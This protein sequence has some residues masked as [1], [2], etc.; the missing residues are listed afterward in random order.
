MGYLKDTCV[1][2]DSINCGEEII[3]VARHCQNNGKNFCVTDIVIDELTPGRKVPEAQAEVSKGIKNGIQVAILGKII[4]KF[5]VLSDKSKYKSNFN[6]IRKKYYGHLKDR[7]FIQE[8]IKLGNIT[9]EQAKSKGF[10]YKGYGECSCIAVA[11]DNPQKYIIV[12]NDKGAITLKPKINLF[13]KYNETHGIIVWDYNEWVKNTN[14][15]NDK[16]VKT[17]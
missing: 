6:K 12:T 7:G 17:S 13:K 1:L 16:N 15:K 4:K 14:Y 3:N 5:D 10:R 9:K 2:I 11:M 8:Q